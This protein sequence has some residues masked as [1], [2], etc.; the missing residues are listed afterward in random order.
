MRFG[1]GEM[2][3]KEYLVCQNMVLYGYV[4]I[5]NHF[6]PTDVDYFGFVLS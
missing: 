6:T 5:M 3:R 2:G 1:F 4:P